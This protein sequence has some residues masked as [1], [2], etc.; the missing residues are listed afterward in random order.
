MN[1]N[2]QGQK[3]SVEIITENRMVR[4]AIRLNTD[5]LKESLARQNITMES[6]DVTTGEKGGGSGNRGQNLNAWQELAN[7]QQQEQFWSSNRGFQTVQNVIAPKSAYQKQPGY[8]ML[9]IHY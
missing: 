1:L 6:F 7:R 2:L 3:L 5:A 8:S 9:D 4:D